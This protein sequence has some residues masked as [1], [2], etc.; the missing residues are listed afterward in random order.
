MRARNLPARKQLRY[1]YHL[2]RNGR[3][4]MVNSLFIEHQAELRRLQRKGR[5][6]LGTETDARA[7]IWTD[8]HGD[9]RLLA[10]NYSQLGGTFILGGNHGPNRVTIYPMRIAWG[11]EGAGQDGCPVPTGDTIVG[12]DVWT[13]EGS[14]I[15]PGVTIGDGAVVAAGAVVFGDVPPYAIVAGNPAKVVTYRF[16]EDQREALLQIRWWDWP[17]ERVLEAV[18]WL[19]TD[20]VDEFIAYARG[21]QPVATEAGV[22]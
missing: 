18:P 4:S 2:V 22:R 3:I 13:C 19:C 9:E 6:V 7:R 12:S 16:D 21:E 14:L 20:E 15:L 1:L 10:G 5:V 17:H 8:V 11:L